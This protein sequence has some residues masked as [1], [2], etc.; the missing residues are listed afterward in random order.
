M[1]S[2]APKP[3]EAA[4]SRH[5]FF[6]VPSLWSTTKMIQPTRTPD[7]PPPDHL[8]EHGR[9]FWRTVVADYAVEDAD[10]AA[11]LEHAATCLDRL[12]AAREAIARDG[13]VLNGR[14]HPATALEL[15]YLRTFRMTVRELGLTTEHGAPADIYTRPPRPTGNRAA[16][17]TD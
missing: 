16:G 9:R 2:L 14:A 15:S 13:V 10:T 17:R 8:G 1:K 5:V 4:T 12:A 7:P 3:R 11:L 6:D